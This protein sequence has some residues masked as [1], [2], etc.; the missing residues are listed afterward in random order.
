MR[1]NREVRRNLISELLDR[2]RTT[3]PR[4]RALCWSGADCCSGYV[5]GE[6]GLCAGNGGAA[7]NADTDCNNGCCVDGGCAS[8]LEQPL[9]IGC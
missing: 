9:P 3:S 4:D 5:C 6:Y 1:S 7:C 8:W 2:R